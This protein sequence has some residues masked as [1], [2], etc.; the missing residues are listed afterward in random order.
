MQKIKVGVFLGGSSREREVSFAGGRTVFDLLDRRYFEPIPIFVDSQ[1]RFIHLEWQLLYKGTIRDFYP[2][3]DLVPSQD[4]WAQPYIESYNDESALKD[5]ALERIGEELFPHQF[6]SLFDVAYL[7]LH[8]AGGEDGSIQGLLDFYNIPYTGSSIYPSALGADKGIQKKVLENKHP[9]LLIEKDYEESDVEQVYAFLEEQDKIVIKPSL[10]GSSVG[11]SVLSS[12][13]SR[14][15]IKEALDRCFSR[16][17]LQLINWPDYEEDQKRVLLEIIDVE[18]GIGL[19]LEVGKKLISRPSQLLEHLQ[20]TFK[21]KKTQSVT[22]QALQADPRAIV[23]PYIQGREFSCVVL[24]SDREPMSLPPTEILKKTPYYAFKAKYLPGIT[25]KKT[26]LEATEQVVE[27]IRA[28]CLALYREGGFEVYARIDGILPKEGKPYLNDPNTTSGMLP[29]SFFF[30]QA[31]EVGFSPSAIVSE[32]LYQSLIR[33]A[34]LGKYNE[35]L[36]RLKKLL[37]ASAK[38]EDELQQVYIIFGGNSFERHISVESGRNV[39]QK[40]ESLGKYKV[41]PVFLLVDK[42]AMSFYTLPYHL[43]LK[44]N[45]DDIAHALLHPE[46]EPHYVHRLRDDYQQEAD[47]WNKSSRSFNAHPITLADMAKEGG[48][49]FLAL[50][51]RPG[52]DGT[53]QKQLEELGIPYNGSEPTSAQTTINKFET[54]E[55]LS[56]AGI[57][58]AKHLLITKKQ[59]TE[60]P[61]A[62]QEQLSDLGFPMIAKP[63]DDGCSS[64]VLKINNHLDLAAYQKLLFRSS[65]ELPEK[66]CSILNIEA[67]D[68]I[69]IKSEI[70]LEELIEDGGAD[71]FI[72]ITGGML[73]TPVGGGGNHYEVF[74]PSEAATKKK[75]LTLAEKFLAGEGQNI[76]PARYTNSKELNVEVEGK[77]KM[78]LQLAAKALEV[79][80][81]CRIDA[82]VRI[83]TEPELKVEVVVIEINSLPG[84]TPATCIFHQAALAG[85]TPAQF[86]DKII[87]NGYSSQASRA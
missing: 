22:L 70:L 20:T 64:A 26:P 27:Q 10:G 33:S 86:L 7:V 36:T 43:L 39:Y 75:I 30:H 53:L 55:L 76:T 62:L 16:V 81:Y 23:E 14:T 37:A 56:K 9:Y 4:R 57:L 46:E 73:V 19:P 45:A 34:S 78:Q 50:H 1:H 72:E 11:V 13:A 67:S 51:G 5:A 40:L 54:N 82:F 71:Y 66:E 63:N 35:L 84:L 68:E 52:E 18:G 25:R 38:E 6:S 59:L 85:Y 65:I 60:Q 42:G 29:S 12:P 87:D 44:D 49:A 15:A 61:E 77:V 17:T 24:E 58:T 21:N 32:V 3:P 74:S 2:A 8:G 83:W 41:I 47:R 31:A 79:T 69:P 28:A 48:F 80:G